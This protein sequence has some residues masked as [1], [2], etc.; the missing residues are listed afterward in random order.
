MRNLINGVA[1]LVAV[2][3]AMGLGA[4]RV[5]NRAA[6][7]TILADWTLNNTNGY[8]N[9]S[10]NSGITGVPFGYALDSVGGHN[11]VSQS[12]GTNAHHLPLSISGPALGGGSATSSQF[13]GLN[14]FI[15]TATGTTTL[16]TNN[17]AVE[18]WA[19]PTMATNGLL[20]ASNSVNTGAVV[21][22]LV[23]GNWEAQIGSGGNLDGTVIGSCGQRPESITISRSLTSAVPSPFTSTARMRA[24]RAAHSPIL[25]Q[26]TLLSTHIVAPTTRVMPRT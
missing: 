12:G 18:V 25:I 17:F 22:G 11:F 16:P 20:F 7:G 5:G 21:I 13:S 3:V 6:A 4:D 1:A 23:G 26:Y 8:P 9:P 14:G 10:G 2:A 24:R 15:S 19:Q